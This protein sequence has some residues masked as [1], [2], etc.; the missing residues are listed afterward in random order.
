MVPYGFHCP[1]PILY[2]NFWAG[3]S[4][5]VKRILIESLL[6]HMWC[7]LRILISYSWFFC[8]HVP[9]Q[10]IS[11]L[12]Y[13]SL[14][15]TKGSPSWL[16]ALCTKLII[17]EHWNRHPS[18]IIRSPA[19]KV[20]S[21]SDIRNSPYISGLASHLYFLEFGDFWL[22]NLLLEIVFIIYCYHSV[23]E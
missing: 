12:N 22:N 10:M 2:I 19:P 18:Q 20:Y 23:L 9:G 5:T 13:S 3:D 1:E 14:H 16:L 7:I 17:T 4:D 11:F 6:L 21:G 8:P 15:F